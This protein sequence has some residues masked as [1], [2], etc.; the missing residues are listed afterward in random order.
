[1]MPSLFHVTQEYRAICDKLAD[2]DLDPQTIADT[3]EG[4]QWPVQ[5]KAQN[6]ALVVLSLEAQEAAVKEREAALKTWRETL[7]R[8]RE[9][10]LQYLSDN[11][12]A[13][14][15]ERVE[16]PDV[17]LSWRKSEAVEV[18]DLTRVPARYMIAPPPPES[19]P[20]KA[21]IKA[22]IKRGEEVPGARIE[23]RRNLQIK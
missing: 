10:L 18:E 15:I 13:A 2:L 3:L 5:V 17:R 8:R 11:L 12:A 4:E 6:V 21:A 7:A 23:V 22:A 16:G 14:G 1:M 9:S 19:K 20:D